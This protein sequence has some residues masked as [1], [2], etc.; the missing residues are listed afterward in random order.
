MRFRILGLRCSTNCWRR[1]EQTVKAGRDQRLGRR[2]EPNDLRG[3]GGAEEGLTINSAD[4]IEQPMRVVSRHSREARV[5][6]RGRG[7][8]AG[9]RQGRSPAGWS[10]R[11]DSQRR[12]RGHPLPPGKPHR[13]VIAGADAP[14]SEVH[15]ST[16][17]VVFIPHETA[18]PPSVKRVS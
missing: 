18:P 1:A 14:T 15:C 3:E 4:I 8:R 11:L 6:A 17:T 9:A 7:C 5:S 16:A 10:L 2:G 13:C 12:G